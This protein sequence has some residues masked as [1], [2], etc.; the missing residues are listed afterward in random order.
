MVIF[1]N[2]GGISLNCKIELKNY[3]KFKFTKILN[4]FFAFL[5]ME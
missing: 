2:F 4:R 1:L 5:I 3:N